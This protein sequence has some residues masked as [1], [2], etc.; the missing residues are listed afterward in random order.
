MNTRRVRPWLI[1][2][3]AAS[4]GGCMAGDGRQALVVYSPHGK[5]M[6]GAFERRFEEVRPGVDVQVVDLGSQE[7]LDRIRSERANPQAD[8]WWGGP[9]TMF[10]TAADEGLLQASTPEWSGALPADARHPQGLWHGIYVTP[11]VIAFNS[12]LVRPADAPQDWDEVLQPKWR[13]KVLIR[14]PMASGTMRTIFGA[15]IGRSIRT[16][17]DTAQGFDWLRRLDGQTRE[18]VLNPTLL[19]QKLARREGSITLWDMPDIEMARAR[20][21][22]PLDYVFARSGTPLPIDGAAVV[23]G[24]RNAELANLFVEYVGSD[25]ALAAAARDFY[26]LPARS[27][28]PADSLPPALRERRARIVPM[29]V[30][31][32]LLQAR[33]PEWMRRWDET[34]RGRGR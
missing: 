14:D 16:T 31:W 33:T 6:L 23:R 1:G 28:F 24:T 26:R 13:G 32:K 34:V 4:L 10:Q 25:R 8:V 19:Y 9:A 22:L 17:G 21:K 27:D 5:D 3:L 11:S 2:A 30:D 18:Y 20:T 12:E 29:A 7:V 15:I